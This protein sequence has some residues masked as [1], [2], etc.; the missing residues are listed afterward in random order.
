M[1]PAP[2]A[3]Q[4]SL[5]DAL[6]RILYCGVAVEGEVTIGVAGVDLV[7]LDLR[8]LLASVDKVR[9]R[10]GALLPPCPPLPPARAAGGRAADDVPIA[11]ALAGPRAAGGRAAGDVPIAAALA[12]PRAA[13][14]ASPEP[15]PFRAFDDRPPGDGS[16]A[17]LVLGLANLLHEEL[18]RQALRRMENGT[19]NAAEIE[20]VGAA[21]CAQA[22]EIERLRRA[23]GLGGADLDL[24]LGA[25]ERPN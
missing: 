18:E 5:A 8:L 24:R 22:Q 15:P 12:G 4:A 1:Q 25:V 14:P 9:P 13:A 21:L 19:L 20:D 10:L 2:Q 16:L 11:A 23:F 7:L 6:D 17:R 3:Q